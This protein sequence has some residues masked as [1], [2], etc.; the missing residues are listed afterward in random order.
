MEVINCKGLSRDIRESLRIAADELD[1]TPGLAVVVV[2]DDPASMTYVNNKQKACNEVGFLSKVI[3][4][5]EEVN[6]EDV[7]EAVCDL[8]DLDYI[9]GIMVQLPLPEHIEADRVIAAIPPE[10][11]V[12]GLT[13]MSMGNLFLGRQDGFVPCTP[14]G[15]MSILK[16][17]DLTGA[18]CVIVGRSDIVGRPLAALL[19]SSDATVTL[20]HSKTKKLAETTRGA[21]VLIS[22]VGKPGFIT[23]DMVSENTVVIDVGIN[24]LEDGHLVGDV[25]FEEVA[26]KVKAITPVPGGVGVMTVT[27]L[28]ENTLRA[29]VMQQENKGEME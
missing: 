16:R 23:E 14:K 15:I 18:N 20:C 21:D 8:A 6:T 28:L 24:K 7:V 3:R 25:C 27:S 29:A 5:P 11:D 9:H 13:V 2:G 1:V 4:M 26:K 10:K 19:T 17:Y 22:A 12:D